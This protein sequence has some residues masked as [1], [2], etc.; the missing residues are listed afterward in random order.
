MK[1]T[2]EKSEYAKSGV[3]YTQLEPFKEAMIAAGKRTVTF[4]GT[5]AAFTSIK[6]CSTPTE[7]CLN[8][9]ALKNISGAIRRKG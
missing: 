9:E 1:K 4:P 5:G 3:D 2:K 7:E 6:T 8:I